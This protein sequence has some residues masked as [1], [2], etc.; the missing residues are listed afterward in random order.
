MGPQ[1]ALFIVRNTYTLTVST[2]PTV[3]LLPLGCCG[4]EFKSK[5]KKKEF[6]SS[7]QNQNQDE[8]ETDTLYLVVLFWIRF[9]FPLL[10]DI[11]SVYSMGTGL[12]SE[13][14]TFWEKQDIK[15]IYFWPALSTFIRNHLCTPLQLH[16]PFLPPKGKPRQKSWTG[17]SVFTHSAS[18]HMPLSHFFL[19]LLS[20]FHTG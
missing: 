3:S 20:S 15:S 19:K 14:K 4:Q 1:L 16:F 7:N 12:V 10:S 9:S 6:P 13:E 2:K 11:D 8:G 18:A 5:S 17:P